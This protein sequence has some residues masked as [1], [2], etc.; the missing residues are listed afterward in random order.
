[1]CDV[2]M[3]NLFDLFGFNIAFN[4]I[5]R[6]F[7]GRGNQYILKLVKILHCILPGIGKHLPT[8]PHRAGSVQTADLRGGR[9]LCKPLHS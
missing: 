1:M 9:R 6:S 4:I 5:N 2:T 8:F 3:D 7:K